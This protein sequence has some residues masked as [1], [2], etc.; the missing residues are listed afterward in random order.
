MTYG[1]N[2]FLL[3]CSIS[4]RTLLKCSRCLTSVEHDIAVGF[5]EEFDE[6][7]YP[8]EDAVIDLEDVAAQLLVTSVPMQVLCRDDCKGLCPVC[9]TN[10]NESECGC[11]ADD[12]DPRLEALRSLIDG[13][14]E[15]Y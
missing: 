9:G 8:G 5:D 12:T 10:L 11:T 4:A 7:E 1:G 13:R 15:N 14:K 2:E 6:E 3:N